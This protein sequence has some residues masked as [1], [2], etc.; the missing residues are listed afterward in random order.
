MY[1]KGFAVFHTAGFFHLSRSDI[2][3]ASLILKY[4]SIFLG[5]KYFST[6]ALNV[7]CRSRFETRLCIP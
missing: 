5:F 4:V 1:M 6:H 7:Q 3:L 2:H